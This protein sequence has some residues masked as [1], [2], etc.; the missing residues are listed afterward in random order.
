MRSIARLNNSHSPIKVQRTNILSCVMREVYACAHWH[1]RASGS[2]LCAHNEI[3]SD[4]ASPPRLFKRE[5]R[6]VILQTF[7]PRLPATLINRWV[8]RYDALAAPLRAITRCLYC[9]TP[10]ATRVLLANR[11]G[12]AHILA[13][14]ARVR[15]LSLYTW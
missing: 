4:L 12:C 13:R 3:L 9:I 1:C 15:W 8:Y 5:S 10:H 11:R 6:G 2:Q 7:H 14:K